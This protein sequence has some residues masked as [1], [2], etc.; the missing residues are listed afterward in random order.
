MVRL[1][2]G[3]GLGR[4]GLLGEKS[5]LAAPRFFTA[6]SK[7]NRPGSRASANLASARQGATAC[8][9]GASEE[10]PFVAS[11]VH[12]IMVVVVVVVMVMM[13]MGSRP[14]AD[15]NASSRQVIQWSGARRS[16][17]V[18]ALSVFGC[19]RRLTE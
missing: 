7:N 19:I 2:V 1:G 18:R 6:S 16:S 4:D 10:M 9:K 8:E 3:D 5:G 12:A 15:V 13:A 11:S 14:D 17:A